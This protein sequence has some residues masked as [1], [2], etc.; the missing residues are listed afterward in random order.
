MGPGSISLTVFDGKDL[1]QY[2]GL[3]RQYT[4]KT[5][6]TWKPSGEIDVLDF[7]RNPDNIASASYE[8][9][10]TID[11][12]GRSVDCWVVKA[13]YRGAPQNRIAK[14]VVRRVWISKSNELI[15][16]DSWEGPISPALEIR[17]KSTTNYTAIEIDAPLPDDLFVFQ[18]T[19]GSRLGTNT[20]MGGVVF[21]IVPAPPPAAKPKQ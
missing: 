12:G 13:D 8:Q 16:R 21:G 4:K 20:V 15:L 7:G 19:P 18:P 10:E 3:S 17:L 14:G 1:W 11:F 9:D 5:V 6:S 2:S